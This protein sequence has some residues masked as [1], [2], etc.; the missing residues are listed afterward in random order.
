MAPSLQVID[1]VRRDPLAPQERQAVRA[2]AEHQDRQALVHRIRRSVQQ[3]IP[4]SDFRLYRRVYKRRDAD[5]PGAGPLGQPWHLALQEG[6]HLE[7]RCHPPR[8]C[9]VFRPPYK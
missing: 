7:D 5:K 3:P 4:E 2:Q 6:R 8:R 9:T 1:L